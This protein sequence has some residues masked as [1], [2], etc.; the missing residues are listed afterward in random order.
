MKNEGKGAGIDR[1]QFLGASGAGL[2]AAATPMGRKAASA[3]ESGGA[4]LRPVANGREQA[5]SASLRKIPIGVFDPVYEKVSLEEMLDKVSG[6]GLEAMEI[7]T[8]GYPGGHH[9]A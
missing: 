2:L 9:G 5:A 1:R 7:G 4:A 6:L 3:G 8:G